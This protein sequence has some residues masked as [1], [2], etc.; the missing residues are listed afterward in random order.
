MVDGWRPSRSAI[1]PIGRRGSVGGVR[2]KPP[3]DGGGV[4]AEPLGDLADRPAGFREAEEGAS[5]VEVELAVGP[6]QERL[7]GAN[8][9]KSWG[10]AL[11]DRTHRA[12]TSVTSRT[13][14]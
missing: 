10:F 1:S 11:R 13:K 4:A 14:G 6:G 3:R 7:R 2:A 8:P 12:I 9:C 5:C